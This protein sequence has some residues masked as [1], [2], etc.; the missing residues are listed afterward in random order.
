MTYTQSLFS[1]KYRGTLRFFTGTTV[2]KNAV[3]DSLTKI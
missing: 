2:I 1:Q 3:Y